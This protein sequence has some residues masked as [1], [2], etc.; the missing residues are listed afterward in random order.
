M[1]QARR[2]P[3]D[4]PL[5]LPPVRRDVLGERVQDEYLFFAVG[6]RS[7]ESSPMDSTS[8]NN[9]Q[10]ADVAAAVATTTRLPEQEPRARN[11]PRKQLHSSYRYL[12]ATYIAL[13]SY[14][15]RLHRRE[16]GRTTHGIF[17]SPPLCSTCPR[18]LGASQRSNKT[19]NAKTRRTF[20]KKILPRL[21]KLASIDRL[22]FL[23][24]EN[25]SES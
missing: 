18:E 22:L 1:L 9:T 10:G 23:P 6:I 8:K 15:Q 17:C 13:F 5:R 16:A 11:K 3:L 4:D 12:P 25:G 20:H 24:F 21:T 19:M 14:L 2:D 7:F